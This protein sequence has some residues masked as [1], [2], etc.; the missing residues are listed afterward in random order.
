M[1]VSHDRLSDYLYGYGEENSLANVVAEGLQSSV[2]SIAICEQFTAGC[3]QS[4]LTYY[5]QGSQLYKGGYIL[6]LAAVT[7]DDA[8]KEAEKVRKQYHADLGVALLVNLSDHHQVELCIAIAME[9]E[10]KVFKVVQ[11]GHS[12]QQLRLIATLNAL[13]CIRQIL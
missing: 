4:E 5:L 13:N 11:G 9:N 3:L 10:T 7:I 12:P 1:I 8:Q 2:S 6:P